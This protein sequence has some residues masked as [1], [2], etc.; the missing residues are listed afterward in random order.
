MNLIAMM[1]QAQHTAPVFA[2]TSTIPW[3]GFILVTLLPWVL[4]IA[5]AISTITYWKRINRA[6]KKPDGTP[7]DPIR[8]GKMFLITILLGFLFGGFLQWGLQEL[9]AHLTG[10]TILQTKGMVVSAVFTG[11]F[12]PMAYEILR[13]V[14][15]RRGWEG[16]YAV[17]TV[18]HETDDRDDSEVGDLT[19]MTR[20][21]E[22]I[23]RDYAD[24]P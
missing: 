24:E 7:N 2:H 4:G 22:T 1:E 12:T 8:S 20:T 16:F 14:A 6:G 5:L 18:A 13:I 19:Q 9:V 21:D 17:L 11:F 23:P 3:W 10:S 15:R